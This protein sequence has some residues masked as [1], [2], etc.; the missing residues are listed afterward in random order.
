MEKSDLF[1][2]STY[3]YEQCEVTESQSSLTGMLMNPLP[4]PPISWAPIFDWR[5]W[6]GTGC[7]RPRR[8]PRMRR[9]AEPPC[10]L[11][12]IRYRVSECLRVKKEGR[13]EGR[14]R[15][16][17]DNLPRSTSTPPCQNKAGG[18]LRWTLEVAEAAQTTFSHREVPSTE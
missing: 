9:D 8:R 14:M 5:Y 16:T 1:L 10:S 17:K 3:M 2:Y 6:V 13:P 15:R 12:T 11:T 4:S 7:P 18:A